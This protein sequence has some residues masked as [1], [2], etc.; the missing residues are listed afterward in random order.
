MNKY[1]FHIYMLSIAFYPLALPKHISATSAN[2][3]MYISRFG[4]PRS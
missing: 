1:V 4:L 2:F 3:S